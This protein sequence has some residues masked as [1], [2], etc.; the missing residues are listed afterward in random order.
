MPSPI[1]APRLP[2]LNALRAF[3]AAARHLTFRVAA[4]EIGVTQGAVAQQ[5]RNLEDAPGLQLFDRLPPRL[6]LITD[7]SIYYSSVQ[8]ALTI[9]ANATEDHAG[10]I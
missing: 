4:E 2:P 10:P 7:G 9:I 8:R 5:V 3:E 6:G 1:K